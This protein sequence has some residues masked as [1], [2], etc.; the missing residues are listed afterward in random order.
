MP[1]II[2]GSSG[3]IYSGFPVLRAAS[4]PLIGDEVLNAGLLPRRNIDGPFFGYLR[5]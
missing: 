4:F 2:Y 5:Y 3:K 1:E